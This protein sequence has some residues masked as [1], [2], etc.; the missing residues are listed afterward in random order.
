M[1]HF[2]ASS[3]EETISMCTRVCNV[4]V[5]KEFIS[6]Q[7]LL[8]VWNGTWLPLSREWDLHGCLCPET[9]YGMPNP[10]W[11]GTWLPLSRDPIWNAF[12]QRPHMECL[13]P[14]TPY[15]M[16]PGCLCPENGTW[17]PL[18]R[19]PI[20]NGTWLPL[21]RVPNVKNLYVLHAALM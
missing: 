17:L 16:E 3:N 18:S 11:N 13:C 4:C 10:V 14:E 9:P 12:V 2:T 5:D 6:G 15:G 8:G 19:D 7:K 1:D 20:W 21:S